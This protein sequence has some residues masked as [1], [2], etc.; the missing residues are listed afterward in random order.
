MRR[1]RGS[2]HF[3]GNTLSF[4]LPSEV[5]WVFMGECFRNSYK[6]ENRWF[7]WSLLKPNT[8][9]LRIAWDFY[10]RKYINFAKPWTMF[11]LHMPSNPPL[12][13][14]S[15]TLEMRLKQ[16]NAWLFFEAHLPLIQR[17]P[18]STE[19][20]L[21]I[22]RG[23]GY[24]NA[25]IH[26]FPIIMLGY[27]ELRTY[28]G[29]EYQTWERNWCGN[30]FFQSLHIANAKPRLSGYFWG[31]HSWELMNGKRHQDILVSCWP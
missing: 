22:I 13:C 24:I 14:L 8:F 18:V 1:D 5:S 23:F 4:H 7:L 25:E 9:I 28:F 2:R 29:L 16:V 27:A 26:G 30:W 20:L 12:Y 17:V 21:L 11:Y 19:A 15:Y 6:K 31:N 10:R 3:F